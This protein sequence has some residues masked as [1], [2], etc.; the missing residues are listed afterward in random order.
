MSL[1]RI[2]NSLGWK[3][4]AQE[5]PAKKQKCPA[6]SDRVTLDVG[7]TKFVAAASTLTQNS[8][9]FKTLLSDINWSESNDGVEGVFIDQ[10]P[11]AFGKLLAYM[12]RGLIKV[13][14]IDSDVLA[15]AEFLMMEKFL[16][17]VKAR[18]YVNIGKGPVLYR[19]DEAEGSSFDE[20]LAAALFDQEH[21]GVLKAISAGLF[22]Q[23]LKQ[24]E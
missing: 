23:F 10:G 16:L 8:A 22:P 11:E 3:A 18:W 24:N 13:E 19:D 9:Y 20:E 21:G 12:R 17:A 15:L 4:N 5:P 1:R 7:G 14:D 6:A 2:F